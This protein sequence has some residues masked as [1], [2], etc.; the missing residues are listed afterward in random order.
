MRQKKQGELSEAKVLARLLE[1]KHC[2]LLPWGD[3]E[4]FDLVL[5]EGKKHYR[6]QVKTGRIRNGAVRFKTCRWNPFKKEKSSY[7]GLID[8]FIVYCPDNDSCYK[9]P[10][11]E[12][13]TNYGFIR[14]SKSKNGQVA[15]V[16]FAEHYIL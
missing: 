13:E 11:K 12:C 3:C 8:Y 10:V 4:P 16:K 14:L 5:L 7:D 2:V 1:L 6:V 15:G 9:I